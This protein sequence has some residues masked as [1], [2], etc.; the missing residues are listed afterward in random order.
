MDELSLHNDQR[1][2]FRAYIKELVRLKDLPRL[3]AEDSP[4]GIQ[5]RLRLVTSMGWTRGDLKTFNDL[6]SDEFAQVNRSL[7][8]HY[9][10]AR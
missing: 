9:G 1:I 3:Y 2:K 8:T 4:D 7:E 5:S 6:S 10:L